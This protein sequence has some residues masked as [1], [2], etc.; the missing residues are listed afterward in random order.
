MPKE[1]Y[2]E[3]DIEDLVQKGVR[4]LEVNEQVFLTALAYEKASELGLILYQ[5]SGIDLSVP[6]RPYLSAQNVQK[7]DRV[8]AHDSFSN[9]NQS[10]AGFDLRS[11]IRNAV[12]QQLGDQI[13][14]ALLDRIIERVL[15][16][17]GVK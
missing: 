2:T 16:S 15:H 6:V 14:P 7:S 17:T 13:D 9:Q 4:S 3:K 11:R 1:F 10:S 12:R 5:P 8:L